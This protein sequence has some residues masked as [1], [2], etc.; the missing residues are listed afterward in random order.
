MS[1]YK[2]IYEQPA[3]LRE[4]LELNLT[5]IKEIARAMTDIR[6]I[7]I[8]ARGT[9]DNAA[10]YAKYLWGIHNHLPVM[11][12]APTMFNQYSSPPQLPGSL[13][14]AISQSGQS[15]DILEVLYEGKRQG[16]PTLAI[17]NDPQSPMGVTADFVLDIKAGLEEAVAATKTYTTQLL[18]IAMLSVMLKSDTARM[19]E[20]NRLPDLASLILEQDEII[21]R[22]ALRYR[23]MQH[24]VV[25]GRGY[26][27]STAFEW[28]L[29][30]KEL[31]YVVA[32]P[33]SSADFQHGPIAMIAHGFPVMTVAP[34]GAVFP[35]MFSVLQRL[36]DQH[37]AEL[38]VISNNKAALELATSPIEMPV[39]TPEWISPI[40][41]II[42]A[43]LFSYYVAKV[44]GL[45][46]ESPRGLTKV[47]LTH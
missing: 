27:Y 12:A 1:L 11:L 45:D 14:V 31:T 39:D 42:P 19:D 29:K 47:T 34:N 38:I 46:T 36:R 30:L 21:G 23:Y 5:R 44:K 7:F 25:L 13:V 43:Q 18:G 35:D 10:L 9:S 32:E 3:V 20:L 6:S 41:S 26:N 24:C 37:D 8:A 16:C 2:E 22:A 33:Y 28:S 17:T 15:P 4:A 40:I